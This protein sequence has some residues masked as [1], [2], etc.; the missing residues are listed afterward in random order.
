MSTK[1]GKQAE[2]AVCS[3]LLRQSFE[4]VA[5]NWRTR[6]CEIDVIALRN[7]KVY[8]VEVKYRSTT[9]HGDG[10]EY[11]TKRKHQKM[12]FAAELFLAKFKCNYQPVLCAVSVGANFK[13]LSYIEI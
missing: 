3:W 13:I 2:Q 6:Y 7:N 11:I 8:F 10:M 12:I 9:K 1:L 5:T 4:V